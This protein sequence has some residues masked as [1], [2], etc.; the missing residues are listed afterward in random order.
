MENTTII[1]VDLGGTN[2]RVSR[3]RKGKILKY[4]KLKTPK[5]RESIIKVLFDTI[6]S[7]MS[8]KV[9]GIGVAS[10]GPLK[11]GWIKRLPWIR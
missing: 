1:G 4:I 5:K 9:K 11:D 7:M 3:V 2:I 8:K 6:N 10:P